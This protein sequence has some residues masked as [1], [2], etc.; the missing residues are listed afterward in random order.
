MP[1]NRDKNVIPINRDRPISLM[2]PHQDCPLKG[3]IPF[4]DSP[5][6]TLF[7]LLPLFLAGMD[8]IFIPDNSGSQRVVSTGFYASRTLNF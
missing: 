5:T 7:M 4:A 3:G 8:Y 6:N 2:L 1:Q